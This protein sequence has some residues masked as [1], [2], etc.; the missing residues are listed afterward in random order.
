MGDLP[1]YSCISL[2]VW[3]HH[4]DFKEMLEEKAWWELHKDSTCCFE[5]IQKAAPNKTAIVWPLISHLTNKPSEMSETYWA[6]LEK[7]G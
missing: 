5:Q 6:L 7:K 4:L 3:L 1:S 2:I